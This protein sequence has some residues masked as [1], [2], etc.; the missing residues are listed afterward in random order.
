MPLIWEPEPIGEQAMKLTCKEIH[1]LG[2]EF[3]NVLKRLGVS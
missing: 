2:S 1:V 3:V